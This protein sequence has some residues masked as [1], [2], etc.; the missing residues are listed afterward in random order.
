MGDAAAL[1]AD[2]LEERDADRVAEAFGNYE[3]ALSS[4]SDKEW[5]ALEM[6]AR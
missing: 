3:A 2:A 6:G 4:L 1:F 5:T